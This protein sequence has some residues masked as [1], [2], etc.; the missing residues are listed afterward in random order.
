MSKSINLVSCWSKA[1]VGTSIVLEY[2]GPD[3][4][5]RS[6]IVLDCGATPIYEDAIRASTVL[7]SHSHLDHVG[8][9]FSHARAHSVAYSG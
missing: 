3:S 2:S 6:R 8:A 5:K 9:I 7:V 4:K 1:G